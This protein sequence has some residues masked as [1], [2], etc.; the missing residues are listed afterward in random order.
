MGSIRNLI[1]PKLE[2]RIYGFNPEGI[3]ADGGLGAVAR[4]AVFVDSCGQ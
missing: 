3:A 2:R 4:Q 1:G